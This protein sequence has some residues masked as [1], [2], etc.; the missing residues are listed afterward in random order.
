M[1]QK[2]HY[3]QE[4]LQNWVLISAV[5][6]KQKGKVDH[7]LEKVDRSNVGFKGG[8]FKHELESEHF[9]EGVQGLCQKGRIV[10]DG[11]EGITEEE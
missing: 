2:Q 5:E 10:P 1:E 11:E 3:F 7:E 9:I 6:K 8:V 4:R